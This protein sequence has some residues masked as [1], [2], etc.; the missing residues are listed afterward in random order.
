MERLKVL[1]PRQ[2]PPMQVLEQL[3]SEDILAMRKRRFVVLWK[4]HDPPAGA[5]YD[6]EGLEF[7]P[8][9]IVLECGTFFEL[10]LRDRVN[11]ACRSV[12]LAYATDG[13]LEAIASRYPGGVPKME[14]EDDDHYRQR[15]WL[16]P[17]T[18]SRHGT[19]EG[20]EFWALSSP[21][22][23][24]LK[25][26]T[27]IKIRPRLEN[28]PI[29][30]ITCMLAGDNPTPSTAQLLEIR[31]YIQAE[32]RQAL[33]DVIS[34]NPP[35]IRAVNYHMRAWFYPNVEQNAVLADM[36][37][38]LK[39]LI[40]SLDWLGNDHTRLDIAHAA[41]VE[42]VHSIELIEP[43]KDVLIAND[44]LVRVSDIDIEPMRE[45]RQ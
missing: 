42:G 35:K 7:D 31:R 19:A 11:Q 39:R 43:E 37:A 24:L 44:W 20:Y 17:N 21:I 12:T 41:K 45:R 8:V 29:I 13:D 9:I 40:D 14:G 3:D 18:L 4:E 38:S 28:N 15:I 5:V 10:Q 33:T 23:P 6:V 36:N 32:Y 25:D 22:G 30:V 2:L 26:V 34:V 1:D 27:A 16:S